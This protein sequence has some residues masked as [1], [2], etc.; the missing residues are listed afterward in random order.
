MI[1]VDTNVMVY[2]HRRD[3]D[4]HGQASRCIRSLAEGHD[5]WGLPWPC[6]HEFIA[7]VSHPRIYDPP[8]PLDRAVD[9]VVAWLESP[10]VVLLSEE[11]NY[12]S[13]LRSTLLQA[14]AIGPLVHDARIAAL[15]QLHGVDR[16]WTL[17]RDFGRFRDLKTVN[18][19]R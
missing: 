10:S 9:Q 19:L 7:I 11:S 14:A 2:A 16:L 15:C 18:P 17:D 6:V 8:T 5:A 3:S 13:N 4:F 1:A 12:W